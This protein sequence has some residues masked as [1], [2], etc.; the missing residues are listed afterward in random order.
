MP[1][2]GP[3]ALE[4][5]GLGARPHQGGGV[6]DGVGHRHVVAE[7]GHVPHHQG[8]GVG[9]GHR[10]DVVGHDPDVDLQGVA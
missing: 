10:R 1:H 2:P 7:P 4:L 8:P 9:P 6:D 5:D 3:A